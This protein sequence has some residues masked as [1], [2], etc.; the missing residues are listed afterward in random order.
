MAIPVLG[1]G[2]TGGDTGK[3]PNPPIP[4]KGSVGLGPRALGLP[5]R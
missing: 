5:G 3:V 4:P 1:L 2:I